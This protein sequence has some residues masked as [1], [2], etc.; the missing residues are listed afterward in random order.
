MDIKFTDFIPD[1]QSINPENVEGFVLFCGTKGRADT[2]QRNLLN[3]FGVFSVLDSDND[4]FYYVIPLR[5]LDENVLSRFIVDGYNWDRNQRFIEYTIT[6]YN[7]DSAEKMY[8]VLVSRGYN[9]KLLPNKMQM[10]VKNLDNSSHNTEMLN[11]RNE[12]LNVQKQTPLS[13]DDYFNKILFSGK[14]ENVEWRNVRK[15]FF[16]IA[17]IQQNKDIIIRSILYQYFN[18]RIRAYLNVSNFIK[19]FNANDLDKKTKQSINL[20]RDYLYFVTE[21]YLNAQITNAAH[22]NHDVIIRFDYLKSCNDYNNVRAVI[23]RAKQWRHNENSLA[24]NREKRFKDLERGTYKI[25]NLNNGY[26]AVQLF[27]PESLDCESSY[28]EHCVGDGYYDARVHLENVQIYSIRDKMNTPRLTIEVEDGVITQCMGRKNIVPTDAELRTA[29]RQLMRELNLGLPNVNSWNK[30]IA[31]VKQDDNL[32]DIFDFPKNFIAK[33]T[34]NISAMDL[35]V[36]PDMSTVSVNGDFWCPKN[37]L[38]SL[39]GAPYRVSGH[40][41]FSYNPLNTLYG[42][43]KFVGGKIYLSN[44]RLTEKSF[45]P[46]Y[47]EN[48]LDD[49]S[50]VDEKIIAA[51]REQINARKNGILSIVTSLFNSK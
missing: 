31:Y 8:D 14:I 33:T 6:L 16:E 7:A 46:L 18:K 48:K 50:G 44:T 40:C 9:V 39:C 35:D 26:Y 49:I 42:M 34:I 27:T 19:R 29:V 10:V 2:I 43:P 47:M 36:L 38:T 22:T 11:F 12:L 17:D 51:W 24:K 23:K 41:K 45:V 25:M 28:M 21:N 13:M 15:Q 3:D 4:G 30:L 32:Y 1:I 37:K 5:D 20:V